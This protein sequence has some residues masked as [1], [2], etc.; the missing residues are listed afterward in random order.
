[1]EA[2]SAAEDSS[3]AWD[4][5]ICTYH[6]PAAMRDYLVCAMCEGVRDS[7]G[8]VD[9]DLVR[10][11]P[12]VTRGKKPANTAANESVP[13]AGASKRKRKRVDRHDASD[14]D[15]QH[16][17]SQRAIKSN[18]TAPTRPTKA[19]TK[20][21]EGRSRSRQGSPPV[22]PRVPVSSEDD[23]V[24]DLGG[25]S[26]AI[27]SLETPSL[28]ELDELDVKPNRPPEPPESN[29]STSLNDQVAL[30]GNLVSK[31]DILDSS[32]DELVLD[33]NRSSKSKQLT[34]APIFNDV[35]SDD[36]NVAIDFGS[37]PGRKG[38]SAA[39]TPRLNEVVDGAAAESSQLPR[40][41]RG[42]ELHTSKVNEI[43]S[44]RTCVKVEAVPTS[45]NSS[46]TLTNSK[47]RGKRRLVRKPSS[48][49]DSDTPL[50]EP[51]PGPA[52][53]FSSDA[54][55]KV[56]V[57][58][59]MSD[60]AQQHDK[61]PQQ[62]PE[63]NIDDL[64]EPES[65]ITDADMIDSPELLLPPPN[66]IGPFDG[67]DEGTEPEIQGSRPPSHSNVIHTADLV[68][69]GDADSGTDEVLKSSDQSSLQSADPMVHTAEVVTP[70]TT[71]EISNSA[72]RTGHNA[73]AQHALDAD[74][75]SDMDVDNHPSSPDTVF[76]DVDDS[77]TH[78]ADWIRSD[79]A[80]VAVNSKQTTLHET[81]T[82]GTLISEDEIGGVMADGWS[83]N[84]GDAMQLNTHGRS[85]PNSA[86]EPT[87]AGSIDNDEQAG[88]AIEGASDN[89]VVSDGDEFFAQSPDF[90]A[91]TARATMGGSSDSEDEPHHE[92]DD[93]SDVVE[94][95]DPPHSVSRTRADVVDNDND[96][97]SSD[98]GSVT[99][100]D[101][102]SEDEVRQESAVDG[103]TDLRSHSG[104]SLTGEVDVTTGTIPIADDTSAVLP[105][106]GSI[107]GPEPVPSEGSAL[108]NPTNIPSESQHGW[109]TVS[110]VQGTSKRSSLS[111][112]TR[113]PIV[114]E[115]GKNRL[116]KTNNVARTNGF[117]SLSEASGRPQSTSPTKIKPRGVGSAKKSRADN[118]HPDK[119]NANDTEKLISTAAL[120]SLKVKDEVKGE[121]LFM[122][123]ARNSVTASAPGA[124]TAS[125]PSVQALPSLIVRP[126]A[127]TSGWAPPPPPP[128]PPVASS[129][130]ESWPVDR[131]RAS[132][133]ESAPRSGTAFTPPPSKHIVVLKTPIGDPSR[134][135]RDSSVKVSMQVQPNKPHWFPLIAERFGSQAEIAATLRK[136]SP[137][138]VERVVFD[139]FLRN[140]EEQFVLSPT[141]AVVTVFLSHD[142]KTAC[143]EVVH[144]LPLR[145]DNSVMLYIF[146]Y[147]LETQIE[148]DS[149]LAAMWKAEKEWR[150]LRRG[151][152]FAFAWLAPHSLLLSLSLSPSL[153][154]RSF[155][156]IVFVHRVLIA[157][158]SQ[159]E[160]ENTRHALDI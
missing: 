45:P 13:A 112:G 146:P 47:R 155:F 157:S 125:M 18:S 4:C 129:L 97:S 123:S 159:V 31:V 35:A 117:L 83:E 67:W 145:S 59:D 26:H 135:D 160:S 127:S 124:A 60:R 96:S 34:T 1:M 122:P 22:S 15:Q 53:E 154:T 70:K 85:S 103:S 56:E 65:L 25:P 42:P 118:D 73:A 82:L 11:E 131:A 28:A 84:N 79:E 87:M 109:S 51:P 71:M 94:H 86:S 46:V 89:D 16:A 37:K 99:F 113:Q 48:E 80:P 14:T 69:S 75:N 49:S 156:S 149:K 110:K 151:E 142:I 3:G 23:M 141:A 19:R 139:T 108:N 52:H 36:D 93:T 43:E 9:T 57:F 119:T 76:S 144:S 6:H 116:R 120:K 20:A 7:G 24:L 102:M 17:D 132:T 64:P 126:P 21:I 68:P 5:A 30:D 33:L 105:E 12:P 100:E 27:D 158:R 10:T 78:K 77:D 153:L 62:A 106:S 152:Y 40:S 136:S 38:R 2:A 66:V 81:T 111:T 134:L 114:I 54:A 92:G 95:A 150:K 39:A 98:E 148:R 41:Q 115:L 8:A 101:D 29:V 138:L 55:V 140:G 74:D 44:R 121:P 147:G 91:T 128:Q 130:S 88:D 61:S 32:S 50:L 104:N 72:V 90:F 143:S 58:D 137:S 133:I 107:G 63:P